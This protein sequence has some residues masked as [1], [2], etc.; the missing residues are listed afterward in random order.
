MAKKVDGVY[1]SDPRQNP[2]A[3]KYETLDYID[4]INKGLGVMD[5][6]A[7]SLCMDNEIPIVVFS[8][9]ENGNILKAVV[10]GNIGTYV[11]R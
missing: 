7:A 3:R 8:I 10:D 9:V 4:V 1:D 11:G 2:N 5:S 6:T